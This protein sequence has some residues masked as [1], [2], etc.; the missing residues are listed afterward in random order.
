MIGPCQGCAPGTR[1]SHSV[2]DAIIEPGFPVRDVL[3]A[4]TRLDAT[5]RE[6]A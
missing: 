5:E 1:T 2:Q 3:V 6:F 4:I